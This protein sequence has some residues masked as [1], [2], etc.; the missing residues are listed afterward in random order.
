VITLVNGAF[1]MALHPQVYQ[2]LMQ[3]QPRWV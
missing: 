3:G 1:H 2:P